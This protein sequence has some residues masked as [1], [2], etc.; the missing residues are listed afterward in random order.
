MILLGL[1][2]PIIEGLEM[3]FWIVSRTTLQWSIMPISS[4]IPFAM[5]TK[6]FATARP[7]APNDSFSKCRYWDLWKAHL[8]RGSHF[9]FVINLPAP[10]IKTLFL[11][12]TG[13]GKTFSNTSGG[14]FASSASVCK[15][16]TVSFLNVLSYSDNSFSV[17][18]SGFTSLLFRTCKANI[19][20]VFAAE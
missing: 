16:T 1:Y 10:T 8:D 2:Y 15:K 19:C 6:S 12:S 18:A 3:I 13:F 5:P 17:V 4:S 14:T 11:D 7:P 20:L 9:Q